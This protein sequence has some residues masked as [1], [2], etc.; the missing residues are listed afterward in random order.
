MEVEGI[1]RRMAIRV[2]KWLYIAD[3][4]ADVGTTSKWGICVHTTNYDFLTLSKVSVK[5]TD[6]YFP[7]YFLLVKF[8]RKILMCTAK[9]MYQYQLCV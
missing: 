9:D 8:A 3:N 4:K 7:G 1:T 2:I 6:F 5:N